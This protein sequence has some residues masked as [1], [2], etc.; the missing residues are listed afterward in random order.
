M[1]I[2][3]TQK[4]KQEDSE[5]KANLSNL[6]QLYFKLNKKKGGG[7]KGEGWGYSSV[8]THLEKSSI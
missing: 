6:V 5:F 8:M 3:P 4:L 7:D 1:V 2:S